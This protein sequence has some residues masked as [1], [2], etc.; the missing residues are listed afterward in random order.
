MSVYEFKYMSLCNVKIVIFA[1]LPKEHDTRT[2]TVLSL[3]E[4]THAKITEA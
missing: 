4:G 2:I 1:G 3:T